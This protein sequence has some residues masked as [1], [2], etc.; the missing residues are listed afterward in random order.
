M[1]DGSYNEIFQ[2]V[3][4]RRQTQGS[5]SEEEYYDL[6]DEVVE[7]FLSDGIITPDD[8]LEELKADLRA[9]WPQVA[10]QE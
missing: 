4:D 10:Q 2:D 1:D 9:R 6:I 8:D 7:E 5:F 3:L